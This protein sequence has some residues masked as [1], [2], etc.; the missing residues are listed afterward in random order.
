MASSQGGQDDWRES[1]A[2][3][4]YS[5]KQDGGYVALTWFSNGLTEPFWILRTI[6]DLKTVLSFSLGNIEKNPLLNRL[7]DIVLMGV[8]HL[9]IVSLYNYAE[10]K[11]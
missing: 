7:I 10:K 8:I 2:L 4:G 3:T 11:L 6:E 9:C 1:C 5:G